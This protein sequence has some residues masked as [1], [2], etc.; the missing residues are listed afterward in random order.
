M[1]QKEYDKL[2]IHIVL[3]D[4]TDIVTSSMNN[5]DG[6]NYGAANKDWYGGED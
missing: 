4:A 3:L 6:D 5:E 2:I 1:K